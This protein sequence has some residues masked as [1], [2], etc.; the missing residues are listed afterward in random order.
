MGGGVSLKLLLEEEVCMYACTDGCILRC[1]RLCGLRFELHLER[2]RC[3]P[4]PTVDPRAPSVP[5]GELHNT[6]PVWSV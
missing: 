2:G 5:S 1:W 4:A 6:R 3:V